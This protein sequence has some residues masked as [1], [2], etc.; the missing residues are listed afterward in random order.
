MKGRVGREVG[1]EVV[2]LSEGFL[3]NWEADVLVCN[4]FLII[5]SVASLIFS[6]LTKAVE[7]FVRCGSGWVSM[8][9][10]GGRRE[11]ML[12]FWSYDRISCALSCLLEEML[13]RDYRAKDIS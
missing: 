12:V 1:I 2:S 6:M 10:P 8:F 11:N 5:D 9:S 13:I 7:G 4:E 3:L